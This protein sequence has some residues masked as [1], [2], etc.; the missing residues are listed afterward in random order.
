[1]ND[2]VDRKNQQT[3]LTYLSKKYGTERL[4]VMPMQSFEAHVAIPHDLT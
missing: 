1:M 4:K 2:P 3:V